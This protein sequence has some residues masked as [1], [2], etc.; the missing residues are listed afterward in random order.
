MAI[1][2]SAIK[3]DKAGDLNHGSVTAAIQALKSFKA[4]LFPASKET[5]VEQKPK[6]ALDMAYGGARPPNS[7]SPSCDDRRN[8]CVRNERLRSMTM[9]GGCRVLRCS[10]Q[11]G[12]VP[13]CQLVLCLGH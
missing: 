12:I 6:S 5:V 1:D 9:Y 8:F 2:L 4:Y 3:I 13:D 11:Y 7:R 10:A